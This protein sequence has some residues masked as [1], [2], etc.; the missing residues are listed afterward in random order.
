[1]G[2]RDE[3]SELTGHQPANPWL[4]EDAFVAA[5]VKLARAGATA[6]TRASEI[7]ASKAYYSGKSNCSTAP[8]NSYANS[9][10]RLAAEIQKNL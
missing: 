3:V 9:I 7:A 4:I 5:A 8:C 2:Y 10:Q 1:M 6:K